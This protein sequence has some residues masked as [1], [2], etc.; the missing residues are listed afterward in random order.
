M[1]GA[2][3]GMLAYGIR[4]GS[5]ATPR[6]KDLRD[7]GVA[8]DLYK[9]VSLPAMKIV[10]T[11]AGRVAVGACAVLKDF[12]IKQVGKDDYLTKTFDEAVY[13]QLSNLDYAERL[14]G[15]LFSKADFYAHPERYKSKFAP[16]YKVSDLMINCIY[17]D[18]AASTINALHRPA[19]LAQ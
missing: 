8:R 3:N 15:K 6:M 18:R 9:Q 7:Y 13:V 16:Y 17:Y 12:G 5:F 11:G 10:V 14:D 19:R 4:T 2:H 1:V